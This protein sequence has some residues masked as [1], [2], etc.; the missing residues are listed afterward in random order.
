MNP[1]SVLRKENRAERT[2]RISAKMR[3]FMPLLLVVCFGLF[4]GC[5]DDDG[6]DSPVCPTD[7]VDAQLVG[8]W[9]ALDEDG[10]M[11]EHGMRV[12]QDGTRETIGVHWASG[13]LA[14]ASNACQPP[15]YHCAGGHLL[16][17]FVIPGGTD[18]VSWQISG[19]ELTLTPVREYALPEHFRRTE[20]GVK[21]T[22]PVTYSF[23]YTLD[24]QP[25]S[26]PIIWPGVPASAVQLMSDGVPLLNIAGVGNGT[27]RLWLSGFS[28]PG[29]Y[30]LEMTGSYAGYSVSTCS[31]YLEWYQTWDDGLS[32]VTITEYDTV[33]LRCK[34]TFDVTLHGP[35]NEV[36]HAVGSFD[37]PLIAT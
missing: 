32:T 21:I 27:L 11:L 3:V 12:S 14:I 30:T 1:S 18:T 16:S 26:A 5:S 24:G 7:G 20:L 34:G 6:D 29:T 9:V 13:K 31:D 8:D 23:S 36:K 4:S 33:G 10:S 19:D 37:V 35:T 2:M 15:P 22:E 25:H 28:G 17:Y